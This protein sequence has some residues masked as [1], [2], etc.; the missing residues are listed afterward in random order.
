M[1]IPVGTPPIK[2]WDY[3][4]KD[5]PSCPYNPLDDAK[6]TTDV[7]KTHPP[8]RASLAACSGKTIL[9]STSG[10]INR[11]LA[12]D[13]HALFD[14]LEGDCQL[15]IPEEDYIQPLLNEQGVAYVPS[16][17]RSGHMPD[18]GSSEVFFMNVLVPVKDALQTLLKP[19]LERKDM[20]EPRYFFNIRQQ[21]YS[22][23]KGKS[24]V[25]IST[26]DS[27]TGM[28]R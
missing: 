10:I 11:F 24:F 5:L 22:P 21:Q 18:W 16:Q 28:N 17:L 23:T 15:I 1:P 4:Q 26:Y 19:L 12:R 27:Y 9:V 2:W 7:R 3:L 14:G 8:S 20:A 13:I 25:D 6:S